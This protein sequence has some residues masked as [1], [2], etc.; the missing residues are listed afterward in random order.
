MLRLQQVSFVQLF[1]LIK[2]KKKGGLRSFINGETLFK[3]NN[4]NKCLMENH[5][6][7]VKVKKVIVYA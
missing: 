5:S 7:K 3:N 4:N 6:D 2:T 1:F